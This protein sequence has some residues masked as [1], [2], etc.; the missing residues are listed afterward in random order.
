MQLLINGVFKMKN[1]KINGAKKRGFFAIALIVMAII[2]VYAQQYDS[3]KDFQIDWDPDVKNGVMILKYIGTKNRISIP[4]KIQN[5]PVT[6][7]GFDAFKGCASLTSVTI[8]DS[9]TNIGGMAFSGCSGL[10][11]V[12]FQGTIAADDFGSVDQGLFESPFNGDLREKYLA[13]GIGTYT[14]TAPVP[15]QGWWYSVW[16]KQ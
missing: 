1:T 4:P 14:T 16:T 7:I 11:S 3:E 5:Y 15:D 10:T 6:S 13:G 12:T 9:V 8:P 2:P